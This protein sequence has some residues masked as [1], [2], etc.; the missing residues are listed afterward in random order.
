M[1]VRAVPPSRRTG[2]SAAASKVTRSG[3][4]FDEKAKDSS[5]PDTWTRS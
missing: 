3:L 1:E 2:T 4:S 5:A